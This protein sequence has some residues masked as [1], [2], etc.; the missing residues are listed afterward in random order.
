MPRP[1][2]PR[3][4]RARGAPARAR[5][6]ARIHAS[7]DHRLDA[8]LDF[9]RFVIRPMPLSKLLDETPARLARVVA[10]DVAS[11][12][13]LE[14]QGNTLVMRGNVGFPDV[15]V[16]QV[17]LAVGEGITGIAVE[18]LRPISVASAA[19]H[20]AYRHFPE[21]G[22]EKYPIF[23]AVPVLGRAGPLGVVTVQRA[24]GAFAERDI[25]L[26]VALSAS[27]AAGLRHA[28]LL[29]S[30]RERATP[31]QAGGGTRKVTLTGRPVVA[32]RALGA[33]TPLRRPAS[34]G[35]QG[36]TGEEAVRRVR[37]AFEVADRTIAQLT[38]R[39][40]ELGLGR[41][42]AFLQTYATIVSDARLRGRAADLVA[43]GAGTAQA[44]G[45][46]ARDATRAARQSP[47]PDPFLEERAQDIEDLCDAVV[48]LAS[49][50]PRA[51]LPTRALV[52]ADRLTVF[53]LLVSA[54]AEPSG[55]ALS[56]R[57]SGPRTSVL[58]RLLGVPAVEDVGGLFKWAADGDLGLLDADHGLLVVNPTRSEI[59]GVRQER[60]EPKD[61]KPG[62]SNGA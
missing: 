53:D 1:Q 5:S 24:A 57:A 59:A 54:R 62:A 11:L 17:R 8:V 18:C 15:A 35:A 10:A 28:E 27:I 31:R 4:E 23:A 32:G 41:D 12:Y 25:E 56:E 51:T 33:L 2:K 21:L 20:E 61:A 52:L 48:M 16:G 43:K 14:G 36:P 44:L 55:I 9:V 30:L 39:A 22:E 13:L 50:D 47:A 46:L 42:A 6:V 40:A 45:Q 34:H 38:R 19:R 37:A 29:D 7:G 60:S 49:G 58:L 3:S 26:L